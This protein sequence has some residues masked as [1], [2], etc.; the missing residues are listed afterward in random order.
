MV[1]FAADEVVA[2]GAHG[3]EQNIGVLARGPGNPQFALLDSDGQVAYYV[4]PSP[5]INLRRFLN[6]EVGI[7]GTL[8]YLPDQRARH[9]T[10]QRV[11]SVDSRLLR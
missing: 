3:A 5:G 7:N 4:S 10:A 1:E 6:Q 11:I 2:A 9:V 8:G